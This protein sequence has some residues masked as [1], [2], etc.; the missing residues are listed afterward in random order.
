M[1]MTRAIRSAT[2]VA[3]VT[4]AGTLVAAQDARTSEGADDFEQPLARHWTISVPA[5]AYTAPSRDAMHGSV[6]VLEPDG[7][8]VYVLVKGTERWS[9]GVI[10]GD[11]LF[12]SNENNLLG[13]IYNFEKSGDR[14]D[15]GVIYIPI[16]IS[17]SAGR[18]IPNSVCRSSAT[19]RSSRKS[20]STS[21][22]RSSNRWRT[23]T[24]AT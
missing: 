4:I 10:E 5:R 1:H 24:S 3:A 11:V 18:S 9:G 20:G 12:P 17:T 7:D 14:T 23:S 8:D 21:N 19:Q 13:I 6:L 16:T 15:F 2:V 22:W